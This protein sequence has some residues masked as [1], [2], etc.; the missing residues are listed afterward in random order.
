MQTTNN[1]RDQIL[2]LTSIATVKRNTENKKGVMLTVSEHKALTKDKG[3]VE[4]IYV[5]R[6]WNG[7]DRD[8]IKCDKFAGLLIEGKIYWIYITFARLQQLSKILY[9][10]GINLSDKG[11]WGWGDDRETWYDS[12]ITRVKTAQNMMFDKGSRWIEKAVW[13]DKDA[14]KLMWTIEELQEVLLN[15]ERGDNKAA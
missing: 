9:P 4:R 1:K 12:N 2:A 6:G 5:T 3:I 10:L 7:Y 8:N 13:A 14:G 15:T 11:T